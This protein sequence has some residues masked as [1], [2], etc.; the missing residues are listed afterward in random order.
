MSLFCGRLAGGGKLG[1]GGGYKAS[2]CFIICTNDSNMETYVC[3]LPRF[4]HEM[5]HVSVGEL[6]RNTFQHNHT[7]CHGDRIYS[8]YV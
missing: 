2:R 4:S 5:F 8:T 3:L 7:N 1:G 6:L